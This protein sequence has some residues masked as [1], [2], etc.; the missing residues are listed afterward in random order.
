LIFGNLGVDRVAKKFHR[1]IAA[2]RP[3]ESRATDYLR[4]EVAE[5]LV[6]R[7]LDIKRRFPR[8]L[9]LGSGS[10]HII[11]YLDSELATELVQMEISGTSLNS[12]ELTV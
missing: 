1:D 10:G 7:L 3:E 4:D 11:K 2:L 8:I 6:D 12:K 5:R 9:D